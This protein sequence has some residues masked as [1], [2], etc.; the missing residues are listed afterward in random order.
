MAK[1]ER[2]N[3]IAKYGILYSDNLLYAVLFTI[4]TV[5]LALVGMPTLWLATA[6]LVLVHLRHH[7]S[8]S[9]PVACVAIITM[10]A[11]TGSIIPTLPIFAVMFAAEV[12][13]RHQSVMLSFEVLIIISIFAVIIVHMLNPNIASWWQTRFEPI[14]ELVLQDKTLD[15]KVITEAFITMSTIA[16]GL[17]AL[18]AMISAMVALLIGLIWQNF[19]KVDKKLNEMLL[20]ARMGLIV[21][22]ISVIGVLAWYLKYNWLIDVMPVIVGSL[23]M[24]GLYV[25]LCVTWYLF[26]KS[27]WVYI[28]FFLGLFLY[29]SFDVFKIFIVLTA[30]S[31]Y[32]ADW[33]TIFK[34]VS[35]EDK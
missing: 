5:G 20:N 27:V 17:T 12:Y 21:P 10:F 19:I 32:F 1:S 23:S 2:K 24:Y 33:R 3:F 11:I 18:S 7:A 8:H 9:I 13:K 35:V 25:F 28:M 26:K 22:I 15:N 6:F 16:T 4:V 14:K 30:V 29:L 31:D 34:K